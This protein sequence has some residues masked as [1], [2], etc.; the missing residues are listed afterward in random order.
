MQKKTC[1]VGKPDS[2]KRKTKDD[3]MFFLFQNGG[4]HTPKYSPRKVREK[5]GKIKFYTKNRHSVQSSLVLFVGVKIVRQLNLLFLLLL[6]NTFCL[7]RCIESFP[8]FSISESGY[9]NFQLM[10]FLCYLFVSYW[11]PLQIT[12]SSWILSSGLNCARELRISN[13]KYKNCCSHHLRTL[14][15]E[16]NVIRQLGIHFLSF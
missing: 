9:L 16:D 5:S 11:G 12:F 15:A 14:F 4:Y 3:A 13:L 8:Y 7:F 1:L 6:I 10:P 2:P